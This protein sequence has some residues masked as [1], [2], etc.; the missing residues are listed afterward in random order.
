MYNY[1]M[2]HI[3]QNLVGVKTLA[4]LLFQ[5]FGKENV[6]KFMHLTFSYLSESE[7]GS[8]LGKVLVNN[9]CFAKFFLTR[10]LY[11]TVRM[12]T[13]MHHNALYAL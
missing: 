5:S 9:V 11:Y 7:T 8:C 1:F 2:Y 12:F 3:V 6:D 10:I 4:N 13:C